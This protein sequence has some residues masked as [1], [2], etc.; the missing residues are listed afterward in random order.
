VDTPAV[1][2]RT[3]NAPSHGSGP[4]EPPLVSALAPAELEETA[5]PSDI[6]TAER[7][8]SDGLGI[9]PELQKIGLSVDLSYQQQWQQNFR[10]GKETHG[11]CRFT[12]SY[13]LT[14]EL[15]F[16]Q[17]GLIAPET[18]FESGFYIKA[19]GEYNRSIQEAVGSLSN[20]N[21]DP[22]TKDQAIYVRKWWFWYKFFE[23]KL[24]FRLGVIQT[25]K[26]LFDVS[27]YANHEDKDFL[28]RASFRNPTIPHDAAMGA[29]VRVE[30]VDWWYVQA[31]VF[32]A[33]AQRY[34][35]QFDTAFHDQAWY[36]GMW[37]T[38]LTPEWKTD[39][40]PM[41]GRYRIGFWYD[42]TVKEVFEELEEDEE[43]RMRGGDLGIYGGLDQMIWKENDDP[44]DTQGLGVFTRA[45]GTSQDTHQVSCYW[46]VGASYKGLI[47]G[48]D[49]DVF[50]FAWS[51]LLISDRYRRAIDPRATGETVYEWYYAWH[52]TPAIV[53]SPDLQVITN[54]GG[55]K[56][57]RDAIIG[58]IRLRIV[59]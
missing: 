32:D 40:G 35:T 20:P 46:Q 49:E 4:E 47:P 19:K 9:R 8:I 17:M 31:A 22:G 26:D 2:A 52:L 29:F 45:G 58:G 30:P 41:P 10:G 28:N 55:N 24:E 16:K 3:A 56:D 34:H 15:D 7:L 1:D 12:G 37:E 33:Q 54:P 53:I 44:E 51:N 13:D 25:H 43:P 11:T 36:I 59:F 39:K 5:E 14:V 38:G 50:G 18:D 57:A 27:L 42:P 48:R 6:W 23:E 21:S